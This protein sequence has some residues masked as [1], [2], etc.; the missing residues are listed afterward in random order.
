MYIADQV[1]CRIR[2]VTPDGLMFT[3]AGT[4][5]KG[6]TGNSGPAE[7]AQMSNPDI[8]A[9]DRSGTQYVPDYENCVI[10]KLSRL[11]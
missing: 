3:V 11:V 6:D 5:R 2:V 4:D 9:F 8:I 1:N 10:R 7:I